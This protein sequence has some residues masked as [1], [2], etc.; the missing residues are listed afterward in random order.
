MVLCQYLLKDVRYNQ[1]GKNGY[2]Y[3]ETLL[4]SQLNTGCWQESAGECMGCVTGNPMDF[5]E[6]KQ[7]DQDASEY[8][9]DLSTWTEEVL[10]RTP[11]TRQQIPAST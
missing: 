8:Y 4:S 11:Y 1:A 5:S 2:I 9:P 10:R 3:S 6:N 7:A